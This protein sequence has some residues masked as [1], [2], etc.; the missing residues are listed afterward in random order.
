[1]ALLRRAFNTYRARRAPPDAWAPF[2]TFRAEQHGWLDDYALFAALSDERQGMPWSE[3]EPELARREPNALEEA[4]TRLALEIAFHAFV[5]FLF[6]RQWARLRDEARAR[7]VRILGDLAIFVAQES[8]D[9]WAHP[10][11]FLLDGK[12]KPKVVSGV[13]P[14]YFSA[15]GQLWGTPLYDWAALQ[16]SGYA[17]WIARARR[18]FALHDAIRLDHFR[19]FEAYWEVPAAALTAAE[20]HWATGP[21]AALFDAIQEALGEAPI[22][23]EDLGDITPEVHA[24]R[25]RFGFPG[26]RMLQFAFGGDAGNDHLPHNYTP[27]SVVYTGTHDNDTTRG[28]FAAAPR[29]ERSHALRYLHADAAHIVSAMIRC[30]YASVAALAVVPMQDVL[31]LGSEARMNVPSQP[32]GNW[33]WRY[34][35]EQITPEASRD[36]ARLATLYGR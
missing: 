26:M 33:E 32:T 34:T 8:A 10:E 6:A 36:L 25:R 30:A 35:D 14:D 29:R 24:L 12:G 27:D 4:R 16:R 1:M 31:Q 21:G 18:A 2:Q 7:G 22:L 11:I 9:V 19:G 28:W 13:P 20:G 5:Q 3:W 23:A 17:W 15:T